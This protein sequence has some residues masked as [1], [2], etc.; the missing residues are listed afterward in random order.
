[1]NF[2]V[3]EMNR[4]YDALLLQQLETSV[5]LKRTRELLEESREIEGLCGAELGVVKS[6][7]N[8]FFDDL[9]RAYDELLECEEGQSKEA[10]CMSCWD[11]YPWAFEEEFPC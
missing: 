11:D 1:M 9:D 5:E 8:S 3:Y 7:V 4:D 2:Y 10:D 6:E